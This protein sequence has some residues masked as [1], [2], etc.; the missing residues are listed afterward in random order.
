M[1][2]CIIKISYFEHATWIFVKNERV[3]FKTQ[4]LKSLKFGRKSKIKFDIFREILTKRIFDLIIAYIL[5]S[6]RI[7]YI[8]F[9]FLL[10]LGI[11]TYTISMYRHTE[12]DW[13]P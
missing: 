7:W 6:K 4:N 11:R 13:Q 8:Q 1:I 2:Y 12:M 5:S 10:F 3:I 9:L